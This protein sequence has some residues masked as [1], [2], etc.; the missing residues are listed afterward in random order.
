MGDNLNDVNHSDGGAMEASLESLETRRKQLHRKLEILGD[1]RRG[2]ISVNYRKCGK[3]NCA[4]AR[5]DHPGHGPQYLWNASVGGKTKARNL[6]LGP[7]LDKAEKEVERYR[8]FERL[9]QELVEINDKICDL[10]PAPVIEDENDMEQMK[11]KLRMRVARIRR[12][13]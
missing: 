12:K 13:K 11:K 10:R 9:C 5:K 2:T 8:E 4:C 6:P 3:S 7:E 1:F